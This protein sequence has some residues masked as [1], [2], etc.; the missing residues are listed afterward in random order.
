MPGA[1]TGVREVSVNG[2]PTERS[3]AAILHLVDERVAQAGGQ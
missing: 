1:E 3:W 2:L